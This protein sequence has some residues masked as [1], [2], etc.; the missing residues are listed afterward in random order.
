MREL[1]RP[2]VAAGESLPK[3]AAAKPTGKLAP[4]YGGGFVT[5]DL[6]AGV[7]H[8]IMTGGRDKKQ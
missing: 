1:F 3:V 5:G 8:R 6:F 4:V 2:L 7:V